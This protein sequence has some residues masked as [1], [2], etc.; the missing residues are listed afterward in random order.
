MAQNSQIPLQVLDV[1]AATHPTIG[2][3]CDY[4]C[5]LAAGHPPARAAFDFMAI[6]KVAPNLLMTERLAPETFKFV[7]CGTV[8]ADNFPRDVTGAVFGPNTPRVSRVSW[9]AIFS[10]VMDVPCLRYGRERIDWRNDE[11][12][13]ILYGSCPLLGKDGRPAYAVTCLVFV[14]RS[15]FDPRDA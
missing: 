4:W 6:Y 14:E 10:E 3:L 11:Y 1:E 15:P 12:R 5:S 8:V 9:P 7:Y 13:D 2:V